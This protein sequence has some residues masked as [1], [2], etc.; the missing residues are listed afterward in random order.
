MYTEITVDN[1]STWSDDQMEVHRT[2][3]A[4]TFNPTDCEITF[5]RADDGQCL[6][7]VPLSAVALLLSV[8]YA[9]PQ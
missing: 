7:A 6:V 9:N 2:R 5:A 3:I 4:L 1:A 8:H